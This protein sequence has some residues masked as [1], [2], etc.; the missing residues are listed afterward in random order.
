MNH[1]TVTKVTM[2]PVVNTLVVPRTHAAMVGAAQRA[3]APSLVPV[4]LVTM[5]TPVNTLANLVTM[6]TIAAKNVSARNMV[7]VTA[8][9]VTATA[10]RVIMGSTANKFAA[11]GILGTTAPRDVSARMVQP[12]TL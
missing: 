11:L 7:V 6:V 2:D 3:T 8:P 12:V 9:L 1:V 10:D 4:N 5:V